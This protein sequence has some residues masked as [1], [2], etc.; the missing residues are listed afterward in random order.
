MIA[1][2]EFPARGDMP[3]VTLD[4]VRRRTEAAAAAGTGTGTAGMEDVIYS[5]TRA[6][7]WAIA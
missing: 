5:A 4:L 1:R 7:S 2:F 6:S 3:P